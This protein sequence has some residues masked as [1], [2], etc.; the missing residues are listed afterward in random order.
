MSFGDN[1]FLEKLRRVISKKRP[2]LLIP[3]LAL[4]LCLIIFLILL[5]GQKGKHLISDL[6]F[7]FGLYGFSA[8]VPALD[9]SIRR[10]LS[11]WGVEKDDVVK[12]S[13]EIKR[14]GR[15]SWKQIHIEI[16]LQRDAVLPRVEK[17]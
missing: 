17:G 5:Q 3:I 6:K 14:R 2:V 11:E 4:L 10:L 7:R 16:N 12:I 1:S 13:Q 9:E 15:E 8:R